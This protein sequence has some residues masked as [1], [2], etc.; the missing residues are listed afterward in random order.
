M[1]AQRRQISLGI[2][3][4]WSESSL[5][6]WRKL[7]SFATHWA[8]SDKFGQTGRMPRLIWVFARRTSIY[9]QNSMCAQRRLRSV[10]ASAQFDQSSLPAWRKLGSFATHWVHSDG[11]G[12]TGRMPRLIWV[13]ARRTFIYQQ[14]GMCAQSNQSLRCP[15]E[16]SLAPKLPTERT[17]ITGK[18]GRMSR[19]IWAFANRTF[20]LLVL[21]WGG[22]NTVDSPY[23]EIQGTLWNTSRYPYFDISDLRN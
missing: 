4:V 16:E 17:A 20:I 12:Q 18:T 10:W 15:L 21:P 19:L 13:F 11:S 9:Q 3:T 5:S 1:C 6:A 7:G 22:F 14:N 8:H 23:L 2:R